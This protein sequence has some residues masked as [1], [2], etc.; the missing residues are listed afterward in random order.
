MLSKLHYFIGLA[1][2]LP[3]IF[4]FRV[5]VFKI[6]FQKAAEMS[7]RK[8]GIDFSHGFKPFLFFILRPQALILL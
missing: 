5:K 7:K 2:S 1:Q 4:L 6:R 8:F 3:T